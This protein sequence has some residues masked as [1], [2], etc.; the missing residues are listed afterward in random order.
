MPR[1]QFTIRKML[2]VV[3]I[4]AIIS[5]FALLMARR[6]E[7]LRLAG[8]HDKEAHRWLKG[9][10]DTYTQVETTHEDGS[11]SFSLRDTLPDD[12]SFWTPRSNY[13]KRWARY[14]LRLQARYEHAARYP[15]FPVE[16]DPPEPK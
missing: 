6:S 10:G 2:G 14:H 8:S 11:V 9:V 4:S 3:A 12:P 15:W 7:C 13:A 5:Q 1:V 16:P